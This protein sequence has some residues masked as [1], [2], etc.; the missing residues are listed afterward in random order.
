VRRV[1]DC[2]CRSTESETRD[3]TEIQSWPARKPRSGRIRDAAAAWSVGLAQP[4]GSPSALL[5]HWIVPAAALIGIP[6]REKPQR[7]QSKAASKPSAYR[8]PP[9][10]G[11]ASASPCR[12]TEETGQIHDMVHHHHHHQNQIAA[13]HHELPRVKREFPLHRYRGFDHSR[14]ARKP[15]SPDQPKRRRAGHSWT[16]PCAPNAVQVLGFPNIRKITDELTHVRIPLARDIPAE[17]SR[18]ASRTLNRFCGWGSLQ[19]LRRF[20]LARVRFFPRERAG[21]R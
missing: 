21:M 16:R 14:P 5:A 1:K 12:M 20:P 7:E 3:A 6:A 17:R 18:N 2:L 10:P 4:V 13:Q 9:G 15:S 19:P 8:V 11:F